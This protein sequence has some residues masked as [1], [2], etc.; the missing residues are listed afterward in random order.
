MVSHRTPS[1]ETQART[2]DIIRVPERNKRN[3]E[4]ESLFKGVTPENAPD[5]MTA[6]NLY[7]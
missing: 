7:I 3:K 5:L 6:I 1:Y 4:T 2:Q